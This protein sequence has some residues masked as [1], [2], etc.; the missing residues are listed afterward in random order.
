M[1]LESWTAHEHIERHVAGPLDVANT[2]G[3]G[4]RGQR[5]A[6]AGGPPDNAVSVVHNGPAANEQPGSAVGRNFELVLS[7][8][9]DKHHAGPFGAAARGRHS[10][11]APNEV[12]T[13]RE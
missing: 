7:R 11:H 2:N 12:R 9:V 10:R 13:I 6:P 5:D 8:P 1:A 4:P 3:M